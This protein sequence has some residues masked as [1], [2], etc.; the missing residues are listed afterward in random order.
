M[1]LSIE[2]T[3]NLGTPQTPVRLRWAVPCQ[4]DHADAFRWVS[5]RRPDLLD[6]WM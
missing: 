4:I 2:K 5:G 6:R 1:L 3:K